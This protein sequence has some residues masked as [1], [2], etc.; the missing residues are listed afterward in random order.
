[1]GSTVCAAIASDRETHLVA[2]VDPHHEGID[3]HLL[4]KGVTDDGAEVPPL[5]VAGDVSAFERAGVEVVVDF[6]HLEAACENLEWAAETGVHAVV[7][8]TG[9]STDDYDHFREIFTESN[10]LIAPN[11]AI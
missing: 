7:G 11:F 8:T 4:T 9:F 10:C 5:T 2:A 6:T 3:L 1:M